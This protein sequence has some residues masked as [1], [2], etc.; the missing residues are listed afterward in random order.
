MLGVVQQITQLEV[1][2]LVICQLEV[3]MT[4]IQLEV[5]AAVTGPAVEE[6][7]KHIRNQG[8]ETWLAWLVMA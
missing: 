6:I 1:V 4:I 8:K 2:V 7:I 5:G 3:E